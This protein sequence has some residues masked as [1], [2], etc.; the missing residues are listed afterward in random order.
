MLHLVFYVSPCILGMS[1]HVSITL[2]LSVI[3]EISGLY[4]HGRSVMQ[5]VC[6]VGL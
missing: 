5:P 3:L 4:F 2:M 6:Y 1:V